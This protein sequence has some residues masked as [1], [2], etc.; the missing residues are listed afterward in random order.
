MTYKESKAINNSLLQYIDPT[1]GGSP[2]KFKKTFEEGF[3]DEPGSHF[4]LGTLVHQYMLEPENFAVMPT[5]SLGEKGR[6][7]ANALWD[8]HYHLLKEKS[9]DLE[10]I[11]EN[12]KY[13]ESLVNEFSYQNPKWAMEKRVENLQKE[14]IPF[15]KTRIQYQGKTLITDKT[16][17][18]IMNCAATFNR[19][20]ATSSYFHLPELDYLEVHNELEILWSKRISGVM[21]E[22]KSK[23]DKVIIN[24]Q[25]KEVFLIDLKTTGK[26]VDLF[27]ESF[28]KYNYLQQMTFY[29]NALEWYLKNV[30]GL[31]DY[32]VQSPRIFAV[33]TSGF[34][35]ARIYVIPTKYLDP[36]PYEELLERIQWHRSKEQW[37]YP[38]G[39]EPN[40]NTKGAYII[41]LEDYDSKRTVGEREEPT[42]A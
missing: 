37:Y 38:K 32:T 15:I 28:D 5:D 1:Q 10:D 18:I 30:L 26:E 39:L 2:M 7:V 19:N 42:E 9:I 13:W 8:N 16:L 12:Q 40:G 33:E 31:E 25:T 29:K 21:M 6:Q 23:L 27:I 41:N 11:I 24:H 34:F 22:L 36:Q 3:K 20:E 4:E 14:V 35:E 17:N